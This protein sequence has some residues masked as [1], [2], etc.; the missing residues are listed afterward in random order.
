MLTRNLQ[1]VTALAGIGLTVVLGQFLPERVATHFSFSGQPNAWSSNLS[2]TLF[3]CAMFAFINLLF[4]SIPFLLRKLPVSL[5]NMPNR[6]YWLS[7]ERRAESV[8]RV[9]MHMAEFGIGVN[10]FMMAVEYLSFLANRSTAPLSPVGL[11]V[12][13]SAFLSFMIFWIVRFVRAFRL[14]A[15]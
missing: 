7:P 1:I 13:A 12:L 9:G 8:L 2:N 3:F 4:L 14:P 15:N 6:E 10:L 11:I 5:I